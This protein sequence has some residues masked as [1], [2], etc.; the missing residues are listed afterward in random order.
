MA[1]ASIRLLRST[2]A[3]ASLIE[4]DKRG[5]IFQLLAGNGHAAAEK[6]QNGLEHWSLPVYEHCS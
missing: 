4:D 3:A 5:A 2:A 1:S 6:C